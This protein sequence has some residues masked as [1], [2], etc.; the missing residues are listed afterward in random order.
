M[1]SSSR[2]LDSLCLSD[3]NP[4]GELCH[5]L[6]KRIINHLRRSGNETT[7]DTYT[8]QIILDRDQVGPLPTVQQLLDTS[9]MSC[10]L[11]FEEVPSCLMVQMPRFGKGYKMFPRILP[12]TD[13]DITDLLHNGALPPSAAG[14]HHQETVSAR[15]R[16]NQWPRP[17]AYPAAV[18]CP[19]HPNQPLRDDQNGFSV[20]EVRACP[21]VGDFLSR[22]E[23]ELAAAD[24]GSTGD[25]VK[26]LLQ[27]SYMCLYQR[28]GP[29][30]QIN[31]PDHQTAQINTPDHQ[32]AQINTPNHQTAQIN[33]PNHQTAQINTPNH[34]TAEINTPDHQP[35]QINT[36]DHQPAL[37]NTPD[38]QTAQINTTNCQT[39]QITVPNRQGA[40]VMAV[41]HQTA[42]AQIASS[43]P[44]TV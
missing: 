40:P 7:Q 21:E 41:T 5:I 19:L 23:E 28:P 44:L 31:T 30:A 8:F 20:P 36:P 38:H 29:E 39:T 17:S 12:T 35:A 6:R 26:R 32:T 25:L 4:K 34:Q 2:T 22:S 24:L 18:R 13:L 3:G 11:K 16:P 10:D 33:T 15:L 9:F 14:P 37:R 43:V 27:D 1:F 42:P